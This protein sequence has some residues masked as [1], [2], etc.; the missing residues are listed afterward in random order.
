VE[1]KPIQAATI[2]LDGVTGVAYYTIEPDGYRV[3]ATVAAGYDGE[4]I[5]FEAVLTDGQKILMTV[6]GPENTKPSELE[7]ARSV[8]QLTISS[9]PV[10]LAEI[11]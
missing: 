9:S 4:P 10:L 8:D 11:E 5:R 2:A 6:P 7:I 3:V 1:L